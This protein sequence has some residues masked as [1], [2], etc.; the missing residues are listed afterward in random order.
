[1]VQFV[2]YSIRT[3]SVNRCHFL[4][5]VDFHS[6]L[7]GLLETTRIECDFSTDALWQTNMNEEL[8]E[9]CCMPLNQVDVSFLSCWFV[10]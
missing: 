1:M 10:I 9:K 2:E 8:F 6:E 4:S 7:F 5:T 3:F